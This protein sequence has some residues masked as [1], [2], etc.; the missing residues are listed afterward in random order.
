M[1]KSEKKT[2][3]SGFLAMIVLVIFISGISTILISGHKINIRQ[4]N[5]VDSKKIAENTSSYDSVS[6]L[7]S[8]AIAPN[9]FE[10]KNNLPEGYKTI[11]VLNE[12]VNKGQLI[13]VNYQYESKIDGEN[14]VDLYDNVSDSVGVKDDDM[15]INNAVLKPMNKLFDDFKAAK[16]STGILISSSYRSKAD[17]I[18]IY[19]E[20]VKHT[21]EKST[22]YYV[23]IPG[24]SEHQTGYC[25][26]TAAYNYDGEM[27]ELDG[28]GVYSWLIENCKNYGFILRYPNDKTNITGIGYEGWHFRYVGVPHAIAIM[29][30]KI[31]LEEY[32]LGLQKYT[33]EDGPLLIDKGDQ[34][35]W[36]VYYVPKLEAFNNTDVPVPVDSEKCS[37][38]IS[39]NNIGGFIVTVNVT[40]DPDNALLSKAKTSWSCDNSSLIIKDFVDYNPDSDNFV[41]TS[42][43]TEDNWQSDT[44]WDDSDDSN[45]EY[46]DYYDSSSEYYDYDDST[47]YDENL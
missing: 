24:Y 39:G 20:S 12:D 4:Q 7:S 42:T 6:G 15:F 25:F 8:D 28:E 16:G 45:S 32:I 34:G 38:T 26:D 46:S 41:D 27:I 1:K 36:I 10:D 23:A 33:F 17:Q 21:G 31:C 37:Y 14:L 40:K 47:G 44:F 13:L 2:I 22:A 35:K 29:E 43:D 11:S 19:E 5:A 3:P 30:N 9:A 18:K